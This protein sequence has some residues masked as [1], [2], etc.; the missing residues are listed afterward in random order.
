MPAFN[1]ASLSVKGKRKS[2]AVPSVS[3]LYLRVSETGTK[4]WLLKYKVGSVQRKYT[5]GR[6][7]ELS[8]TV[9]KKEALRIRGSVSL[10]H[11]PQEERREDRKALTIKAIAELYI[12][13][14]AKPRKRTWANDAKQLKRDVLPHIG[15]L[16]KVTRQ[17]VAKLID[18]VNDR[19]SPIASNRLL[20]CLSAMFNW[21]I[22]EGLLEDNPAR[23]IS[24]RGVEQ[25]RDRI[26]TP[27]E[28]RRFWRGIDNAHPMSEP[29]R[30][31]LRLALLT[32]QRRGE[33]AQKPEV[34]NGTWV[35]R[36]TKNNRT[37]RVPLAPMAA[38]IMSRRKGSFSAHSA[39]RA[40]DRVRASLGL[41]DVRVHDLRRTFASNLAQLG[42]DRVVI[43]KCLNHVSID[44]ATITGAV[45]DRYNY[46]REKLAAFSLWEQTLAI[47]IQEDEADTSTK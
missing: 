18:R 31:L 2:F 14:H 12:E 8:L 34:D 7:P 21:A 30:D 40:W 1:P 23:M 47:I 25:S 45:Y 19:G 37:H 38:E 13:K 46:E 27:V 32:G 44:R 39:T 42:V 20:A 43:A 16:T 15:N 11:D 22:R 4:T 10:G 5:I 26:L 33:I 36:H 6:Y 24:K 17:D 35:L 29:V 9:A 3:S 41:S 28:I